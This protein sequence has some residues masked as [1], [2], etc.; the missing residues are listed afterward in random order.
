MSFNRN[1]WFQKMRNLASVFQCF[2]FQ[3]QILLLVCL[4]NLTLSKGCR[5]DQQVTKRTWGIIDIL[6][7]WRK[8]SIIWQSY[9]IQQTQFILY[10]LSWRCQS[11]TQIHSCACV[12]E[13]KGISCNFNKQPVK[14]T[15]IWTKRKSRTNE[16]KD[17][18]E[19]QAHASTKQRNNTQNCN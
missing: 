17:K 7:T 1:E 2:V 3:K 14:E 11:Y 15:V 10:D 19:E 16:K 5:P 12:E 6:L 13:K 8:R 9:P 18:N 4:K